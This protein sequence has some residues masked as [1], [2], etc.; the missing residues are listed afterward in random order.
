MEPIMARRPFC[1]VV[2]C[3]VVLGSNKRASQARAAIHTHAPPHS[4][5][6][7]EN[8]GRTDLELLELE[9]LVLLRVL[10][11]ELVAEAQVPGGLVLV[12]LC[13]YVW[14]HR[15]SVGCGL[16]G[17]TGSI[18]RS[19]L[20]VCQ[21]RGG[22]HG[23]ETYLLAS[24]GLD[25]GDGGNELDE[26][27][28]ALR[29]D[30]VSEEGDRGGGVGEISIDGLSLFIYIASKHSTRHAC[31]APLHRQRLPGGRRRGAWGC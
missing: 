30:L 17:M 23:T 10:R 25:P 15:V 8:H 29:R 22:T 16:C 12:L 21:T 9:G 28:G 6:A 1:G 11:L 18:G 7:R 26:G 31:L 5:P 20:F 3:G 27:Q 2:S 14:V 4:K 24:H 19:I 13:V